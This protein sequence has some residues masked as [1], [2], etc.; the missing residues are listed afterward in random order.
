M[1]AF[2]QQRQYM[3]EHHI[4]ARGVRSPLVLEAMAS[5]PREEFLPEH[6]RED[7]YEDTP[8]PIGSRTSSPS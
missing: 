5:V 8:L 7:A 4:A 2:R 3:V 1:P 6:L